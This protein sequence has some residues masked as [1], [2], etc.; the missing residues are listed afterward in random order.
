MEEYDLK[1]YWSIKVSMFNVICLQY[2]MAVLLGATVHAE[3]PR[4]RVLHSEI[5]SKTKITASFTSKL[6]GTQALCLLG[7]FRTTANS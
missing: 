3:I 4:L 7:E 1:W 6:A 2:L 5:N